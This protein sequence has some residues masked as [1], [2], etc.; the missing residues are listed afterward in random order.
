MDKKTFKITSIQESDDYSFWKNKT[1]L[2]RIAG[3]EKLR[4]ILFGYDPSTQ[5]LQRV[6][7][8]TKLKKD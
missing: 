1:Y 4:R 5:R 6:F 8:I 7:K 2:E 3:L